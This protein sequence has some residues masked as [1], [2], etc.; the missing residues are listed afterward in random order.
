MD[1]INI[2]IDGT[3]SSGKGITTRLLAKKLT[4]NYLDTGAMYRA[5]GFHLNKM[6]IAPEN[7]EKQDLENIKLDFDENNEILLNNINIEPKIRTPNGGI[8]ASNYAT[9]GVVRDFLGKLQKHIVKKGGYIAEGRDIGSV[10]MPNAELKIYLTASVEARAKR[11]LLDFEKTETKIT[12]EEVKKQIGERDHQDMN[13][14][15]APLVKLDD[16]IEVDTSDLTIEEQ[17]NKIYDL[18]NKIINN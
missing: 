9:I 3:V 4:Y 13:R 7:V 5:I 2:A 18:A 14:E 16:A 17:V 11:R 15:I 8:Y 1:K 12:F 6:G 10:I